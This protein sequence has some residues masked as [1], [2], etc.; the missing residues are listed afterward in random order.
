MVEDAEG[1]RVLKLN[2]SML[3]SREAMPLPAL[4]FPLRGSLAGLSTV[5]FKF[6]LPLP[7]RGLF[8]WPFGHFGL[9]SVQLTTYGPRLLQSIQQFNK[10]SRTMW[11]PDW[12][13]VLGGHR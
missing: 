13:Q 4:P 11:Q 12:R 10:R 8:A 7:V 1:N 5:G 2:Y 9:S 3:T 6:A